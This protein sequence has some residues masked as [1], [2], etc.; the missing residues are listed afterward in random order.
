MLPWKALFQKKAG[1]APLFFSLQNG[2]NALR[3]GKGVLLRKSVDSRAS[4]VTGEMAPWFLLVPLQNCASGL[5]C[6]LP[7]VVCNG[8]SLAS[9]CSIMPKAEETTQGETVRGR[10]TH[11]IPFSCSF[12]IKSRTVINNKK[13]HVQEALLWGRNKYLRQAFMDGWVPWERFS[14]QPVQS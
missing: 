3:V 11:Y 12:S 4:P 10:D 2:V 5:H 13:L 14:A 6:P 8:I 7:G 1:K 9:A